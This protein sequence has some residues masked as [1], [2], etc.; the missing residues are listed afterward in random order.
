MMMKTKTQWFT[1]ITSQKLTIRQI[2]TSKTD[3]ITVRNW[4]LLKILRTIM[5]KKKPRVSIQVTT[6]E[7]CRAEEN[8][9]NLL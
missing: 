5:I 8:L 1:I 6:C 2:K 3:L 4:E 9:V 7:I